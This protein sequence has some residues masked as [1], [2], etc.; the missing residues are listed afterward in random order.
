[1][2]N[3]SLYVSMRCPNCSARRKQLHSSQAT[4]SGSRCVYHSSVSSSNNTTL[5]DN[6]SAAVNRS[7]NASTM[8]DLYACMM[9]GNKRI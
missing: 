4:S 5:Y 1:M 6:N 9:T 3:R 2:K 8:A 7:I